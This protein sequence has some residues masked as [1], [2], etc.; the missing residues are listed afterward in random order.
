MA[1][2][3]TTPSEEAISGKVEEGSVAS[4]EV[5]T[6]EAPDVVPARDLM[7]LKDKKERNEA[8][9]KAE[10]DDL[11]SRLAEKQD[12][13]EDD[14]L[15]DFEDLDPKFKKKWEAKDK[16]AER[17]ALETVEKRLAEEKRAVEV[18]RRIDATIDKQLDVARRNGVQIP[19]HFDKNLFKTI[20]LANPKTD[21]ATLAERT[22]WINVQAK[23]TSENDARPAMDYVA[24]KVSIRNMTPEQ[25]DR[26]LK[27]DSARKA[28][29]NE[30][31]KMG[32]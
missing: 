14:D 11:K 12:T 10:I 15:S 23:A 26:A 5:E 31:D 16:K 13:D 7:K 18:G 28:Y 32:R 22:W 2:E 20:V 21:I 3:A 9:L 29:F 6:E 25:Q 27:D 24:D 19:E 4:L 8:K 30:L 17:I 1:D